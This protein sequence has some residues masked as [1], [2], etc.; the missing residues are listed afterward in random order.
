MKKRIKR[1][2]VLICPGGAMAGIFG[3]GIFTAF[4]EANLYPQIK[5]IY[6][7][8]SGALNAACFLSRQTRLG[9]SIYL[10]DL[11]E[12]KFIK[13]KHILL[14]YWQRLVKY[15]KKD[16]QKDLVSPIDL[17]YLF[18]ILKNKKKL[19]IEKILK[20]KIEFKVVVTRLKDLEIRIFN[21]KTTNILKL[22]KASANLIPYYS[23]SI[24]FHRKRY[25]DGL[26]ID[27]IFISSIIEKLKP[28]DKVIVIN[29]TSIKR[30][31]LWDI[32]SFFEGIIA[33]CMFRKDGMYKIFAERNKKFKQ[34][35]K[36]IKKHKNIYLISPPKDKT[37]GSTTDREK[38][39]TTYNSGIK[40]GKEFL[41]KHKWIK[42]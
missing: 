36:L 19:D 3:G 6:A 42:I 41:K 5:T 39:L 31:F 17:D 9:A 20:S 26:I 40:I 7:G 13:P 15:F 35:L 2:I 38:L 22:L 30:N 33:Y 4:E 8:S 32:K 1:D 34:G 14:A 16:Y 25:I 18:D 10:D 27:P 37:I 12:D 11:T 21:G 23:H 28:E 24:E 29:N